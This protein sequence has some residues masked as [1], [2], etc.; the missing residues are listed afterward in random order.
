L[1][2]I[3]RKF[4]IFETGTAGNL[5]TTINVTSYNQPVSIDL[6]TARQTYVIPAS[7]LGTNG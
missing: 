5:T 1:N 4:V 6:P 2:E 7:Q 3:N